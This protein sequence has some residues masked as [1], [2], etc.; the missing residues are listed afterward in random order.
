M[1]RPIESVKLTQPFVTKV[2]HLVAMAMHTAA[3]YMSV[4]AEHIWLALD[5]CTRQKLT[6]YCSAGSHVSGYTKRG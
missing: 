3:T 6:G 2:S 1:P 5:A 4:M